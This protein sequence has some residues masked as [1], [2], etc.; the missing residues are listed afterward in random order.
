MREIQVAF[1][2]IELNLKEEKILRD[3]LSLRIKNIYVFIFICKIPTSLIFSIKL[4]QGNL[5]VREVLEISLV[6]KVLP[7][8]QVMTL[9]KTKIVKFLI[10][11][12]RRLPRKDTLFKTT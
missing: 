11:C 4:L 8:P 1:G 10:P 6:G 5:T 9:L 7:D 3:K 2:H 12:L